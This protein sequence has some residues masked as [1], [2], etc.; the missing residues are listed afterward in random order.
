MPERPVPSPATVPERA[1]PSPATVPERA[2]PS[3][4]AV[5]ELMP[6]DPLHEGADQFDAPLASDLLADLDH[7]TRVLSAGYV[8]P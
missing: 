3:P 7:P 1:V 6:A 4:A 5:P 2:V 8:G